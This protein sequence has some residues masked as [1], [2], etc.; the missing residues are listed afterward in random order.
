MKLKTKA[1]LFLIFL[2]LLLL[3]FSFLL[4]ERSIYLFAAAEAGTFL[5]AFFSIRLYNQ[6]VRPLNLISTGIATMEERAFNIKFR[7]TG[8]REWDELIGLYNRMI[9]TLKNEQVKLEERNLL[10]GKLIEAS[11]SAIFLLDEKKHIT[12]SN[13]SGKKMFLSLPEPL[14]EL[15]EDESLVIQ[16]KGKTYTCYKSSFLD[17]GFKHFFIIAIEMTEVIR[18][19][20]KNAY[21]KVI[22][23]M[24]HE[25]G[26]SSGAVNSII[27]STVKFIKQSEKADG[28]T[29]V[30]ALEAASLRNRNLN[31]FMNRF[32][33]VV[34]IPDPQLEIC[35]L[36]ELIASVLPLF[37]KRYPQV[38]METDLSIERLH[39]KMDKSQMEQ[40]LI[41]IIG[42][43]IEAMDGKG[44]LY[45][46]TRISPERSLEIIDS[47]PGLTDEAKN[48]LFTP[49]FSTKKDGQG[50]GL[51]LTKEILSNHR[52]EFNL[53][54]DERTVFTIYFP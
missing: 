27:E 47:G 21:G 9:E 37:Q 38:Q 24:S 49:F 19:K 43:A 42:N 51:T 5:S 48:K 18:K 41:N 45:I 34:R 6:L 7:K 35:D 11:P 26:N 40:V 2:H 53:Q 32:A 20:E 30:E 23:M 12:M 46:R 52:F 28:E 22:R 54:S 50:I 1:L 44:K 15:G 8:L 10:L 17:K 39:I 16:W 25:I 36:H 4:L 14:I 33:D 31:H 29:Y 3:G 13:P